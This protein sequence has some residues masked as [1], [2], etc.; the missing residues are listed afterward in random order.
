MKRL[1]CFALLLVASGARAQD[2]SD[3]IQAAYDRAAMFQV[4]SIVHDEDEGYIY[5]FEPSQSF[6]DQDASGEPRV[7]YSQ[8]GVL[9]V[10]SS[11]VA[12]ALV[13]IESD[14]GY[15]GLT[16]NALLLTEDNPVG[17]METVNQTVGP[18]PSFLV[19]P[20]AFSSAP[21]PRARGATGGSKPPRQAPIPRGSSTA[22]SSTSS[23]APS[24]AAKRGP[25]TT[26]TRSRLGPRTETRQGPA[27][28][29]FR[30]PAE[31]HRGTH[32]PDWV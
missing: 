16:P 15:A 9:T 22:R 8:G 25:S 13:F 17:R 26:D 21:A 12:K 5:Y 2:S 27:Q 32:P 6:A 1:F 29:F 20:F 28:D 30:G 10:R 31:G 18:A 23:K 3:E 7:L 4:L 14:N 19:T 24:W 11:G